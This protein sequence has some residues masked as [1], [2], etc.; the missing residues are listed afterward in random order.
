[1]TLHGDSHGVSPGICR[2]IKSAGVNDRPVEKVGAWIVPV[3]IRVKDI[4]DRELTER[5][6]PA[7]AA[8]TACKLARE[9]LDWT[10]IVKVGDLTCKDTATGRFIPNP[11]SVA[12]AI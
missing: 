12:V 6:H 10:A 9:L 7:V 2:V 11:R 4:R 3:L 8:A 5:D 1:M